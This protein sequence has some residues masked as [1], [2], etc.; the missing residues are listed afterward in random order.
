MKLQRSTVVLVATALL[1]GGVVLFTQ[2]QQSGSNLPTT[3]QGD[4]EASPVFDFDEADVVGLHIETPGQA[5][6]FEKDDQGFWQMTEPEQHPAEEAAIAF[7]LSRLTTDG[8][9]KTTTIDAANQ[10]EFGLQVPLATVDLTLADGTTH[11]FALGDT[12]FSGQNYY[13]LI[14]P[15]TIPLSKDAGEVEV[16]IV[17]E[18]IFNGVDRPLAEWKA[19]IDEAPATETED[20]SED[21]AGPTT[22]DGDDT[23]APS[24]DEEDAEQSSTNSEGTDADA[25]T[26]DKTEAEGASQ[27]SVP[28]DAEPKTLSES[29]TKL[30]TVPVPKQP[31]NAQ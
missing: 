25:A 13:A 15:E 30:I 31:A 29:E 21:E 1:L 26:L 23:N 18:N 19:V 14:D 5:V 17:S 22:E 2:A 3:A 27:S 9:L 16:A 20:N 24:P 8:L 6:T 28:D 4:T 10:A 7:L 12:D 11:A